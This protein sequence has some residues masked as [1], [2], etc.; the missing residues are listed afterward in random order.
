MI[1]V[2]VL[3]VLGAVLA[4]VGG[5]PTVQATSGGSSYDVPSVVD[6]NADPNIVETSLTAQEATVNLGNGVTAKAQTLNGSIPGPTFR[7]KV[8]D[9]VIVHFKNNLNK[10]TGVHW[11]GIELPNGMDGT[12]L[13][14]NQ[15]QPGGEYLYKFTVNRP[16]IFWYHPHHHS[17]TNQV[18]KGLYG[19]ILV[20]DPN[21]AALQASGT[22]PPAADTKPIVF[23]DTTVCKAPPTNPTT[24]YPAGLP[25][26]SGAAL[27]VQADP[28]PK[29]LCETTA[30]D[31][32]SVARPAFAAGDIPNIQKASSSGRINEGNTLLTNGVNVGA[33]SATQGVA[34]A[35]LLSGLGAVPLS[36]QKLDV[37]A[38]QGLRLQLLNASTIRYVRLR[39]TRTTGALVQ[40]V[41]VGGEGGLLDKAV[42]E[43]GQA[44]PAVPNPIDTGYN[45][46][47]IL[48]P[49]GSRADVVAVIPA[50]TEGTTMTMWTEDYL[51]TGQGYANTPT[52][53][54]MH[55]NVN[56]TAGSPYSIAA[57][58]P[59]RTATGDPVAVLGPTIDT[60]LNPATFAPAK[61]GLA[62]QN[63]K[64]SSVNGGTAL[65][66]DDVKG[67]H[68]LPPG[69]DYSDADHEGSS[70]YV[71]EDDVI[72][73]VVQNVTNAR[74]PFHLH[75]FS[76]Q[77][78]TMTVGGNTYTW[79]YAEFR[80]NVDVP[81]NGTLMFR[82][83]TDPRPMA[84]GTTPGGALG[85]WVFHCHIFFH[86]VNGM[87][88]E[89]VVTNSQ[90]KERP[91]IDADT[92]GVTVNQGDTAT[93]TGT[94][95][96]PDGQPVT[97]SASAGTV[98]PLP[99]GKFSWSY[100]TGTDSSRYVYL[101]ATDSSGLRGQVPVQLTI[102]NTAPQLTV[103][104]PQSVHQGSTLSFGVSATDPDAPDTIAL[105]ASGLPA[106]LTFTD[107][108][109][110]TGTVSGT[111]TAAPGSF[112]P[113][114]TAS[115]GKH[116]AT[117]SDVPITVTAALP[118]PPLTAVVDTPEVLSK[119]AI[120]VG[121]RLATAS[122]KTCRADVYVG[123]KR[124]GTR[125]TTVKKSGKKTASVRVTLS[126][127]TRKKVA[128]S[129]GGVAVK[130]KVKATK[131]NVKGSLSAS[132]STKVVPP[133]IVARSSSAT[134]AKGSTALNAK[135]LKFLTSVAKSVGKAKRATCTAHPDSGLSK[136][137]GTTQAKARAAAACAALNAAGL[138]AKFSTSGAAKPASQRIS[139]TVSR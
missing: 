77:P 22:L 110:R 97:L 57:G 44:V 45:T 59:L 38:G 82:V 29:E 124:V 139:V 92:T 99:G 33:R 11:H 134:F 54:V 2:G 108:G 35:S 66:V 114:F 3:V 43:G 51:R 31:E 62:S 105:G 47:E 1:P 117:D 55:L 41:R 36:A 115:D 68:E 56:G 90:G 128:R 78:K 23:S 138:K 87:I 130:V 40:L 34:P 19:M 65:G 9:T 113:L 101:T 81:P 83:K 42:V 96:D 10:E 67:T 102:N 116:L 53:P 17:S 7:L 118:P 79:P 131:R 107:N 127:S 72:Q 119:K 16:G 120:T 125:T 64:L 135:G 60:L 6:T 94:Y 70:R 32:N 73:M 103:P 75:G 14:Q 137:A 49:P 39:L 61:P 106:G 74:H 129:L 85:R 80:D 93:V 84:D 89:V 52:V 136:A 8:G 18:F 121:C 37:K 15:V 104:G 71:K 26:V 95:K 133:R 122:I 100:P 48:M 28:T 69:T 4:L 88:S 132:A 21:E 76:I 58:T 111:V 91:D 86:A 112:D 123:K 98:T 30:I 5:G 50:G 63:I 24:N 126:S 25:H 20:A 109:N 12:P 27:P 13:T 46:G